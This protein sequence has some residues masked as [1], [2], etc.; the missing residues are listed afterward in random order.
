[1]EKCAYRQ[2]TST[3][4]AKTIDEGSVEGCQGLVPAE[5]CCRERSVAESVWEYHDAG[6]WGPHVALRSCRRGSYCIDH[7]RYPQ[8]DRE[9]V[10]LL[11]CN[12]SS[13]FYYLE[14]RT[15]LLR[16]GITHSEMGGNRSSHLRQPQS[17]GFGAVED[18]SGRIS[19]FWITYWN[20]RWQSVLLFPGP[21]FVDNV[22]THC[23]RWSPSTQRGCSIYRYA[24]LSLW[25][26]PENAASTN[27]YENES[28]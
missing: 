17:Q 27:T 24:H 3:V 6:G 22:S 12:F 19:G 26:Y 25:W 1:M 23:V 21:D 4:V 20:L 9:V 2:V 28:L 15:S 18:G 5:R 8:M 16:P 10:G 11:T 13:E 7:V 14:Q